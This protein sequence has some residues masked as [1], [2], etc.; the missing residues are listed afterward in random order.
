M[1]MARGNTWAVACAAI[2]LTSL[3]FSCGAASA[4]AC[5]DLASAQI[6]G[7]AV[8]GAT[9]IPAGQF[10]TPEQIGY[11]SMTFTV[12]AFCRVQLTIE[13]A[14]AEVWLPA[15]WNGKLT[16][17]GNGG[18][19]GAIIYGEMYYGL[20]GGYVSVSSDLGHQSYGNDAS[21]AYSQPDKI[22]EFGYSSTHD[23]TVAAKELTQLYYGTPQTHSYFIGG[24]AGGRQALMEAQRFPI[25]YDGIASLY[26]GIGWTHLM[27]GFISEELKVGGSGSSAAQLSYAQAR[28]LNTAVLGACDALDGLRDGL[29]EDP[30]QCH[31]DPGA[32]QCTSHVTA[33]CLDATQIAAVRALYQ[34]TRYSSGKVVY[35]GLAY[36][37]EYEWSCS[38]LHDAFNLPFG[39]AWF[40]N[41]V[42]SPDWDFH[43]FNPDIDVPYADKLRAHTLNADSPNLDAFHA[44]GGKLVIAQGQSD[45]VVV[46]ENTINY[47]R[48]VRKR[49]G[50]ASQSFARLF[51]MPGVGHCA[52]AVGPG[53]WDIFAVLV[54]WV[55]KG[56]APDSIV[57]YQYNGDGSLKRSRPLC[58]WPKKARYSGQGDVNDARNF[59]CAK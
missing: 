28:A 31:F 58:P 25:D 16:G 15:A 32:M 20:A 19:L 40:Q 52:A 21:W 39:N 7:A 9:S 5:S 23:M 55:E 30:A 50:D 3:L 14:T 18:E 56:I 12:P 45:A 53:S 43:T 41:E 37:S 29:I 34:P 36:G 38:V 22:R 2:G 24:S 10:T 27:A 46:P 57:A 4:D 17:W 26:P 8:T 48:A 59:T 35:P 54:S 13:T 11:G 1:N 49:Y 47:Y 51:M 42:Y 33:N 44:A 6:T